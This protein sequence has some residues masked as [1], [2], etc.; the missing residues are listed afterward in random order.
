MEVHTEL[1]PD[2]SRFFD[3]DYPGLLRLKEW[4]VRAACSADPLFAGESI[5]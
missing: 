2:W 4:N 5:V 3:P 1:H